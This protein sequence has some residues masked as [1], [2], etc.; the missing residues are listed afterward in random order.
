MVGIKR[1]AEH[2]TM[3]TFLSIHLH[4]KQSGIVVSYHPYHRVFWTYII[5]STS[6]NQKAKIKLSALVRLYIQVVHP[7]GSLAG[8]YQGPTE[9][10]PPEHYLYYSVA[11]GHY[12]KDVSE[13]KCVTGYYPAL[14]EKQK[15]KA[16]GLHRIGAAPPLFYT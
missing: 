15:T 16:G 7:E 2:T 13:V 4:Q 12:A 14:T 1:K 5:Q 9:Q 8:N 3:E 10:R 11:Y 6:D